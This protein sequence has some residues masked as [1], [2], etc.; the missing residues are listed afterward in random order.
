MRAFFI[1]LATFSLLL[2]AATARSGEVLGGEG[3]RGQR[4]RIG[5]RAAS[6]PLAGILFGLSIL[7]KES[8]TYLFPLA[9]LWIL[10][11]RRTPLAIAQ[12]TSSARRWAAGWK[13]RWP[14]ITGSR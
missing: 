4:G 8:G 9:V 1:T 14:A 7:T 6:L 12:A 3:G 13:R 11:A 5:V 2:G 10:C